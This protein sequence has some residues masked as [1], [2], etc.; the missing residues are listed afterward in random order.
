[1]RCRHGSVPHVAF[2]Q[3]RLHAGPPIP[4]GAVREPCGRGL[5]AHRLMPSPVPVLQG[6]TTRWRCGASLW[7]GRATRWG[8]ARARPGWALPRCC[9]RTAV[10][11]GLHA[12]RGAV[13]SGHPFTAAPSGCTAFPVP[14]LNSTLSLNH[15]PPTHTTTTIPCHRRAATTSSW[16]LTRSSRQRSGTPP[17]RR[18][19]TG[20]RRAGSGGWGPYLPGHVSQL[21]LQLGQRVCLCGALSRLPGRC[22]RAA[23]VL[24]ACSAR[25]DTQPGVSLCSCGRTHCCQAGQQASQAC[26]G[27]VAAQQQWPHLPLECRSGWWRAH[28]RK[29]MPATMQPASRPDP[30]AH[31]QRPLRGQ[32]LSRRGALPAVHRAAAGG[33]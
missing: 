7:S 11:R 19:S 26:S 25:S 16:P 27:T 23:V 5:C 15:P 12:Q 32:Q 18:Q 24:G 6:D 4:A 3:W 20:S 29:P 28:L 33:L 22:G 8:R 30:Q 13:L 1:M 21:V 2:C 31:R 14:R 17:S 9:W 10:G